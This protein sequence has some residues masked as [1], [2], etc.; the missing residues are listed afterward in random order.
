MFKNNKSDKYYIILIIE[1]AKGQESVFL[2]YSV[3][4]EDNF[5][6]D[7]ESF[8]SGLKLLMERSSKSHL[9]ILPDVIREKNSLKKNLDILS[10]LSKIQVFQVKKA[11][12]SPNLP[13]KLKLINIYYHFRCIMLYFKYKL[14]TSL[15]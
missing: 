10:Q 12:P 7:Y 4:L 2:C 3:S 5:L 11:F 14:L 8:S 9:Y 6:F 15:I 13:I 1:S